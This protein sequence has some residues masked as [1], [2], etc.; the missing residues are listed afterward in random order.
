M[1]DTRP[2]A[3]DP[4]LFIEQIGYDIRED[5]QQSGLW[6]WIAPT[7]SCDISY[8]SASDAL[9]SAFG[10]AVYQTKRI[11]MISDSN[12]AGMDF[13]EQRV[14]ITY[15]LSEGELPDFDSLSPETQMQWVGKIREFYPEIGSKE[16]FR[17]GAQEYREFDGV[18]PKS[19]VDAFSLEVK[20]IGFDVIFNETIDGLSEYFPKRLILRAKDIVKSAVIDKYVDTGNS[21][22]DYENFRNIVEKAIELERKDN[23]EDGFDGVQD[24]VDHVLELGKKYGFQPDADMVRGAVTESCDLLNF[25]LTED[26]IVLACHLVMNPEVEAAQVPRG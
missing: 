10:D 12:W 8:H 19:K 9:E 22:S 17:L 16:A 20:P 25:F 5:S 11:A 26:E 21:Q 24:V 15:A 4:K 1:I 14:A 3:N 23:D 7:D 6:I 18:F 2:I 13:D